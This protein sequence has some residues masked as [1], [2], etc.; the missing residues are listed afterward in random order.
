MAID[1]EKLTVTELLGGFADILDELKARKIVRSTNNPVGDLSELLF[2]KTFNWV[3]EKNSKAGFDAIDVKNDIRY[4]IKGRRLTPSNKSRELGAIRKIESNEFHF[5]AAI[6]FNSDFSI[7]KAVI[8]PHSVVLECSKIV[9]HTNASKFLLTDTI[10][11]RPETQDVTKNIQ[12]TYQF[13]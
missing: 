12:N 3:Q 10:I 6:L 13:L 2:C 5:L 1:L 8:I 9:N 11:K 4:Q 7:Y